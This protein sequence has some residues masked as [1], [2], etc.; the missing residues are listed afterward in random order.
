MARIMVFVTWCAL[1]IMVAAVVTTQVQC[2]KFKVRLR[3]RALSGCVQYKYGY[4]CAPA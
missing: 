3:L 1:P 4:A 2:F